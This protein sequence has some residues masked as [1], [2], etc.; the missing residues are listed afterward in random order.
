MSPPKPISF[1]TQPGIDDLV[2]RLTAVGLLLRPMGPWGV[3]PLILAAAALALLLPGVMRARWTWYALTALVGARIVADWPLPDNHIYLLGY[4]CLALA[5]TTG[6]AGG[7]RILGMSSRILLGLVFLMA[8]LWKAWLSPDYI[9]GRFFRVTL[10]TDERFSNSALL[11]GGL[12]ESELRDNREYL[13]PLPEGAEL[14]DGPALVEPP[15]FRRLAA[16]FTWGGLAAES[17]IAISFLLSLAGWTSITPHLL[18]LTFC[19][20][21]YAFAP[22]AGFGWLL[23]AMG[24][25]ACPPERRLLRVAYIASWILVLL[26]TEIPWAGLLNDLIHSL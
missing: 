8:V 10:L 15:A 19:G 4:W 12:T 14:L 3:R 17:L 2:L 16:M 5:L 24:L 13:V 18:L 11:L 22:V 7:R 21:T 23:L 6:I 25:A 26:Y 1:E 9:D 20:L